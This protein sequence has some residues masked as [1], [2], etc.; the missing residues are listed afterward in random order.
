MRESQYV[1]YSKN[2]KNANVILMRYGGES[3]WGVDI[4]KA[5]V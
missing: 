2:N 3:K 1:M 4:I 5:E